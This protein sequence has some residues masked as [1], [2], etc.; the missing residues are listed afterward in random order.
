M[1]HITMAS[2]EEGEPLSPTAKLFHEPSLNC[3]V[4][5]TMGCKTSFNPQVIREGLSQTLLKH[6]RFTSIPAKKGRKTRWIPTTVNLDNHIIIPEIDYN[7]E[8]PNRFVEDYI[9]NFIK[10]PLD[11]SKPL[12]ELHLLNIKTSDA[13]AVGVFRIHHSIG[14]CISLISLLL[15]ATRK[16]S[17]PNMLSTQKKNTLHQ[18]SSPFWRWLVAIWKHLVLIWHT[19]VGLVMLVLTFLFIKDTQSSLK[20]APGVEFNNKRFVYRTISMDDIKLVKNETNATI[21][22]VLLGVTQAAFTRYLNRE[23]GVDENNNGVKQRSSVL[24]KINLR[25]SVIVNLRSIGGIQDLANMM[26]KKSKVKWGNCIGF[27]ILPLSIGFHDDPLEYVHQAKT[28]MDRKKHSLEAIFTYA[29]GKLS[30]NLLGVKVAAAITRRVLFNTTLAFSNVPGP[31]KEISFYGHPVE[32][33]APSAYGHPHALTMH[34]LSYAEKM[35]ISLSVDPLVIPDPYLLCDDL[36]QSLKVMCD[37]VKRKHTVN[38][39]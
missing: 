17:D 20:G 32:Y 3:Y 38:V 21:N 18:R 24:K 11:P 7:I 22:D 29:F 28:K 34:F 33:I 9:S 39:V 19:M 1:E 16:A 8:H 30:L 10:T 37:V 31:M 14:D 26:A 4:I 35:T 27:V 23:Y 13:A 5:T 2:R 36:E 25:A 15:A 6:P 12:W